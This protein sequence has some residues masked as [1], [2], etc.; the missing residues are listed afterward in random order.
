MQLPFFK[1]EGTGNDFILLDNRLHR[2]VFTKAEIERLCHRHFGIGSDGL[3]L[4]ED[5]ESTDFKMVFYNPDGSQSFCGNGSRCIVDFAFRIG[6]IG[7]QT[8]FEAIDGVHTGSLHDDGSITVSMKDVSEIQ[9]HETDWIIHTGSPHYIR[10]VEKLSDEN[11]LETG[12]LIRYS[13][14]FKEQGIN[15]NLVEINHRG[16]ECR[17]YERGVENETLS[18]GTG[19]T[20]VALASNLHIEKPSPVKIKTRGGELSVSFTKNKNGYKNILLTGPVK[21]VF[22]GEI[23]RYA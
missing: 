22:K 10:F 17:T 14:P 2:I 4:L 11:I 5:S 16:L 15:V 6:I 1:Y 18:C 3:I 21:R 8:R 19:V 12:R 7:H 20:A 9:H 13:Q 23:S